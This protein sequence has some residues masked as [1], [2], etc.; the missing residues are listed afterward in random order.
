MRSSTTPPFSL[1]HNVYCALPSWMRPRSLARQALTK[2]R[3][4]R[5]GD[6]RL[7]E[8]R[9]V[10]D[11]D[12]RAHRGVLADD[13][14]AGVLDRHLPAAEVGHLGAEGH[15]PV[16]QR[17]RSS[18]LRRSWRRTLPPRGSVLRHGYPAPAATTPQ[19]LDGC[20]R[21]H[22]QRLRPPRPRPQGRRPRPRHGRRPT[23][24]PPSPP[25]TACPVSAAATSRP[26]LAG[27]AAPPA[28]PRRSSPS[29]PCPA[30]P[31]QLASSS[32]G[33]ARRRD[34]A[35]VLRPRGAAPRGRGRRRAR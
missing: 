32:P 7:A 19:D 26:Q 12:R 6:A 21:D 2:S 20:A 22:R 27:A 13:A 10:E 11:A 24:R 4:A 17:A 28:R 15:V 34:G 35:G 30:S 3:G 16:V 5:A 29:P 14:A 9:D 8:V 31:R 23:A 18:G 33:S 25:A 1:Q